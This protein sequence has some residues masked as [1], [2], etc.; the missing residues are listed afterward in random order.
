MREAVCCANCANIMEGLGV[1]KY[2]QVRPALH[3]QHFSL[4]CGWRSHLQLACYARGSGVFVHQQTSPS[5][6]YWGEQGLGGLTSHH[7]R[8]KGRS[9]KITALICVNCI[10][11]IS[12]VAPPATP[13]TLFTSLASVTSQIDFKTGAQIVFVGAV[14][15][16]RNAV[17]YVLCGIIVAFYVPF[18]F[19]SNYRS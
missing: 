15:N 3:L 1:R 6:P 7:S 10:S 2:V 5:V 12:S 14:T 17:R 16:T 13:Q 11:F 18:V 19:Y 8:E 9:I 4:A